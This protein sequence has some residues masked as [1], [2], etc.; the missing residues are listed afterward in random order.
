MIMVAAEELHRA[1]GNLVDNAVRHARA[2]VR[3]CRRVDQTWAVISVSDDGQASHRKIV[4]GSSSGS[5]GSMTRAAGTQGVQAL[6]WPSSASWSFEPAVPSRS[7][8]PTALEHA[9]GIETPDASS[10]TI[11][12]RSRYQPLFIAARAIARGIRLLRRR[13]QREER[14]RSLLLST[15]ARDFPTLAAVT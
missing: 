15:A 14:L 5:P 13:S 12:Y 1:I 11:T 4:S 2:R 6:A 7:P 8:Q 9:G 3:G 10:T